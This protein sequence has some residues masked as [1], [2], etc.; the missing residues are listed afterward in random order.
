[1]SSAA[2]VVKQPGPDHPISIAPN[3]KRVR[4]T[5]AGRVIA[6]T[7]RALTLHETTYKPVHYIPREDADMTVFERTAHQTYCPYKGDCAYYSIKVGDRVTENAAWTYEQAYPA[8]A[9]IEGRLAFYPNR[10]DAIEEV[11]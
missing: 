5:F 7:T 1:V 9:E 8:V 3:G 2:K 10:V 11:A 6:D 4:V